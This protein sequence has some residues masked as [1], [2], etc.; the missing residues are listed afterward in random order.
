MPLIHPTAIVAPE[1]SLAADVV[2]GPHCVVGPGVRLG[3]GTRLVNGVT[4]EGRT[5]IG[6]RCLLY[7]G[8]CVGFPPQVKGRTF[9]AP[10][11]RIGDDNVLREYATV[12]GASKPEGVTVL[13]HRNYL[14]AN[15][16]VAHD[17][18]LGNDIVMANAA[19]LGGHVT[20]DDGAVIGGVVGIHQFV[21]VGRLVMVGALTKLVMDAAPY[22]IVDGNPAALYGPN[23]VGLRRAG[24]KPEEVRAIRKAL[25]SLLGSG[26]NLALAQK[27]V[28]A[29]LG[30]Y[31]VVRDILDF[32]GASKRGM[33]RGSAGPRKRP[34]ANE[35]T[36]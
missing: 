16:H 12:H 17:C 32:I 27:E 20:V 7:T 23:V 5:S 2:I 21:R 26:R 30:Q 25:V 14:M 19:A 1:A 28:R 13:G 9:E 3:E 18:I 24:F 10:S 11:V 6:R 8:V 15:T 34:A 33:I 36:V 4:V 35:E 22:S 29:E 31:E